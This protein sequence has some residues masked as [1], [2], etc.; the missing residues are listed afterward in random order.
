MMLQ[1]GVGYAPRT[2]RVLQTQ[3]SQGLMLVVASDDAPLEVSATSMMIEVAAPSAHAGTYPL[4]LAELVRGPVCLVPP[5]IQ[6]LEGALT[7]EPGLWAYDAAQG[8]ATIT[9]Q[10]LTGGTVVKGATG[11]SF[12]PVAGTAAQD[13]VLAETIRQNGIETSSLSAPFTLPAQAAPE[14]AA[15]VLN[16]TDDAKLALTLDRTSTASVEVIEPQAYAGTYTIATDQLSAGP[17]WLV[18]ARIEGTAQ[19]GSQLGVACPGLCIGDSDAGPVSVKSQWLRNGA[20]IPNATTATYQV[21]SADAGCTIAFLETAT[22]RNG[23]R[24]RLS[25]QIAIGGTL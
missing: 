3:P 20:P 10:W 12:A 5:V 8:A 19:V 4:S 21:A 25:N 23:T 22:D 15:V 13:I 6:D 7:V 16:V 14:P 9:R 24:E 1:I 11:L 18:A 17:L 2:L